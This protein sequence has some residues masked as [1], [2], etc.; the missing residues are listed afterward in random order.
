MMMR[1]NPL[2]K[3]WAFILYYFLEHVERME[4]ERLY[5]RKELYIL[6]YFSPH[7]R[8]DDFLYLYKIIYFFK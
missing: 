4:N 2:L 3:I 5:L 8:I 1:E 6:R 7:S